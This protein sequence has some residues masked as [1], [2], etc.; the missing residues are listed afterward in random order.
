LPPLWPHA[1]LRAI[2]ASANAGVTSRSTVS[3]GET[4][5]AEPRVGLG[6]GGGR[7]ALVPSNESRVQ[8]LRSHADPVQLRLLLLLLFAVT[9]QPPS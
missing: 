1:H 4:A 3:I 8:D 6:E 7:D 5:A 9:P 2:S